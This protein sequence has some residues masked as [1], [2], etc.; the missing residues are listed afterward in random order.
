M[1]L[2]CQVAMD[3]AREESAL[4]KVTDYHE[5]KEIDAAKAQQVIGG[6]HG[7]AR[8]RQQTKRAR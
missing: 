8:R 3:R 6:R 4:D 1:S 7:I 5:E 2:R